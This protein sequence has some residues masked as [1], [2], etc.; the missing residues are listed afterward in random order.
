LI[1]KPSLSRLRDALKNVAV[2]KRRRDRTLK[3]FGSNPDTTR[4]VI[5]EAISSRGGEVAARNRAAVVA[6]N[7]LMLEQEDQHRFFTILAEDFGIDRPT[8]DS[9]IKELRDSEDRGAV[10]R[11]LRTALEAERELL[12]RRFLSVESGLAF[13]VGLRA[14]LLAFND[15]ALADLDDELRRLLDRWFDAGLLTLSQINWDSPASLL[16]KLVEYEAVHAVTSWGDLKNRLRS[17]RRLFAFQHPG[18]PNDLLIFVE[19]ALV[20]GLAN[21]VD[22][23]LNTSA[24]IIDSDQTDT[25]IF[26]SISNCQDGLAGVRLG[27]FLIKKVVT[28]L[29]REQPSLK[30]F[31]TLSPIPGFRR[32][33]EEKL[34]QPNFFDLEEETKSALHTALKNPK[35]G[36]ETQVVSQLREALPKLGAHYLL[37]AKRGSR[38]SDPVANFHLS[39]GAR[40]ERIVFGANQQDV[41]QDRALGMMVNYRYEISKIEDRHD[42]YVH[43]G[44]IDAHNDILALLPQSSEART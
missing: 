29:S 1:V 35:W 21:S 36:A 39:N 11:K 37:L 10:E 23:L 42:A 33:L 31:A 3:D 12:F 25:A 43:D 19:V 24:P 20:S 15:P 9:L 8:V 14:D 34:E 26:Y 28:E 5:A 7:Y 6:A 40:I 27:D 30:T 18:L 17:D 4:I 22:D 44:I 13:V 41:A 16:E 38:A 2:P 32:W